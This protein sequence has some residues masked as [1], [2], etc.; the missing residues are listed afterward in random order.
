MGDEINFNFNQKQ[1]IRAFER[2]GFINRSKRSKHLKFYPPDWIAKKV[3]S[4][5]PQFIMIPYHKTLRIQRRLVTELKRMGGD[6]LVKK[7]Q[8]EL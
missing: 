5:S 7:F 2:L 3:T 6:E 4:G 1:C 8:E